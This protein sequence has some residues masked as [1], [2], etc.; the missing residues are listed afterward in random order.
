M[1]AIKKNGICERL[2]VLDA[3]AIIH[4][5][6]HALPDFTTAT[7]EP[8]GALYG[9]S[10]MLLKFITELKPDYIVA[11]YDLPK[12][13]YRHDAFE[14]YKAGRPRSDEALI[15]QIER[16]RDVLTAFSIP[17]Y[18]HEG[19]EADDIIGTIAEKTKRIKNLEVV[20]ASGYSWLRK[21]E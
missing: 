15:S 17:I 12:P 21:A 13:T 10:A 4:R 16:S 11:A 14:G 2:V 6:Y 3:H 9:L 18:Q 8:S 19:F 1:A 7:G 20:I 5:A